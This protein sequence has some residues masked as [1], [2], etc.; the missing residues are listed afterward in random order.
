M[1][2]LAV[3]RALGDSKYKKPIANS[4]VLSNQADITTVPCRAV[5]R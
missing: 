2:E 3:S 5:A 1:G 4:D